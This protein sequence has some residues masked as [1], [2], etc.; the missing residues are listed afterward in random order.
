MTSEKRGSKVHRRYN[1]FVQLFGLLIQK[2][3]NRMIP[4]LPPKQ[5]N[6]V[7]VCQLEERRVGLQRWLRLMS[8]HPVMSD[9][10]IFI[11][12]L[13]DTSGQHVQQMQKQF[14]NNTDEF[15]N[16]DPNI[17]LPLLDYD[18]LFDNRDLIRSQ[19]SHV[20]KLRRL[21]E[22]QMKRE[23]NQSKD[24]Q[25]IAHIVKSVM[26]E[27]NDLNLRDYPKKFYDI[28]KESEKVSRGQQQQQAVIE[29][30]T[31]IIEMLIA[32]SD[33]CDRI[34]RIQ[35]TLMHALNNCAQKMRLPMQQEV[36]KVEYDM[37]THKKAFSLGCVIHETKFIRNYLQLLSSILLQFVNEEEKTFT[38]VSELLKKLIQIESDKMCV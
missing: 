36:A 2:Y 29:R 7:T 27:T 31:M 4:R 5:L 22:Q 21:V 9:E 1:D 38:N 30:L 25:D 24:F 8:H 13:T 6:L 16:L 34:E 15:D 33:M 10:V 19:L 37:L 18:I 3:S 32:H 26:Q 35:Q 17:Q 23:A 28:S 11:T 14:Q 12:F 20:M